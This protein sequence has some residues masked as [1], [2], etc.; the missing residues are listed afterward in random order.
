MGK[1]LN[2]YM[3]IYFV[4]DTS[5][6]MVGE[7]IGTLNTAIPELISDIMNRASEHEI[8]TYIK[9][10]GYGSK[11]YW[12]YENPIEISNFVWNDLNAGGLAEMGKAFELLADD[13]ARIKAFGKNFTPIVVWFS[14]RQATDNCFEGLNKLKE[15]RWYKKALKIAVTLGD[16]ADKDLLMAFTGNPETILKPND[17]RFLSRLIRPYTDGCCFD[18][19]DYEYACSFWEL[20][21][22]KRN[23]SALSAIIANYPCVWE[24]A[25]KMKAL[26]L[27]YYPEDKLT[28]NLIFSSVEEQIPHDIAS[29]EICTKSEVYRFSKRLVD[30]RGCMQEKAEEIVKL[31]I[32][33]LGITLSEV[34]SNKMSN[35]EIE[36]LGIDELGLSVRTANALKRAGI[37]MVGD[38]MR[39]RGE[40]MM[41]VRNLG[42]RALEEVLEKIKELGWTEKAQSDNGYTE[43]NH[44]G[45]DKCDQLREIR[46]KIAQANGIKF[47]PAECHHT[48][49]CMGTCAVCDSEIR[50]ID[51]EL[52]KKKMR[53]EEIILTGLAADDIEQSGCNTDPDIYEDIADGGLEPIEMGSVQIDLPDDIDDNE[54]G[55]W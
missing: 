54:W 10:M 38:L 16:D 23:E 47:E 37:F 44:P 29:L 34:M 42:R 25:K 24:N 36:A 39:P 41:G 32:E 21:D 50:Y 33:A 46:K 19:E 15:Q 11:A 27:D 55:G 14:Y 26:L 3:L 5:G 45:R 20:Y 9:V 40:D 43:K 49:P 22:R 13:F 48:G 2:D 52:Q 1:Q 6:G 51:D 31:W 18:P 30:S 7:R 35:S 8:S 53:G 12:M 17:T 28:R 4:V